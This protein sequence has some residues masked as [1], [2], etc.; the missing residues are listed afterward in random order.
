MKDLHCHLIPGIDDGCVDIRE[1]ITII[2]QAVKEGV[3]DIM[4]T[5][6]YIEKSEYSCNNKEKEG[7][8]NRLKTYLIK[9]NIPVKIYLGNE[10]FINDHIVQLIKKGEIKPLG[11]SK[12][13]LVEL[14]LQNVMQNVN[15][16]FFDLLLK[17]YTP[18]LAHPERYRIY[19]KHPEYAKELV[20]MGVLL[21]GNY[22]SLFG[23]YGKDAKKTLKYFLKKN[24]ISFLASDM[25]HNGDY[26]IERLKKKLKRLIHDDERIN[27]L[28]EN[29]FDKVIENKQIFQ[30]VRTKSM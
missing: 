6:H 25:H 10:I 15:D 24:W 17:G 29:N 21:Q 5:P 16:I 7:L 19:K 30:R 14:P 27:D 13:L 28:L 18:I 20:D 11:D 23:H 2:R 26:K 4:L 9:H 22:Q 1:C 12:Y 3:T 8:Y